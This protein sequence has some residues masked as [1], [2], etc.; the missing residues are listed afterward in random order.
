MKR[1]FES[2]VSTPVQVLLVLSKQYNVNGKILKTHYY[3]TLDFNVFNVIRV[4]NLG[5][6]GNKCAG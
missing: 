1:L 5:V 2:R 6:L 4:P 3:R